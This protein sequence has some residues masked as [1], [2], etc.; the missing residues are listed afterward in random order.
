MRELTPEELQTLEDA[1]FSSAVLLQAADEAVGWPILWRAMCAVVR[2]AHENTSRGE[3]LAHQYHPKPKH[4]SPDT[5]LARWDAA[6]RA[7]RRLRKE[8]WAK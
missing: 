3:A 4:G 1:A 7:W 8:W 6:N 5:Y 2:V